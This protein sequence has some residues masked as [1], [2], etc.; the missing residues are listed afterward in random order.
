MLVYV[1]PSNEALLRAHVPGAQDQR[2]CPSI[3]FIVRVPRAGGRP[4]YPSYPS[5]PARCTSTGDHLVCPLLPLPLLDDHLNAAVLG[6]PR[7]RV[8]A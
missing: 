6:T 3:P 7:I 1:R 4:G 2:G 8:V 5:E